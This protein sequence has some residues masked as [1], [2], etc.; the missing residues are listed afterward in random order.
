MEGYWDG[1][2]RGSDLEPEAPLEPGRRARSDPGQSGCLRVSGPGDWGRH[3]AA[4]GDRFGGRGYH[5]HLDWLTV[6]RR[7]VH[8]D[9]DQHAA[10]D[11]R[12]AY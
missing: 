9:A 3:S 4:R 6:L 12:D 2:A 7:A 5:C 10:H 8:G 11:H 1:S